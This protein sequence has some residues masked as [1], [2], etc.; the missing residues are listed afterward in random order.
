MISTY[1][2]LLVKLLT[3]KESLFQDIMAGGARYVKFLWILTIPSLF[4]AFFTLM[5]VFFDIF[6]LYKL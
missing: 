5:P 2:F 1:E 3:N 4:I 6:R